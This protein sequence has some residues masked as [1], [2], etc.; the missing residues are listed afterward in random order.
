LKGGELFMAVEGFCVKCK[1][2]REIKD[3]Q[4]VMMK[5]GRP[6]VKGVCPVC[7]TGMFRIKSKAEQGAA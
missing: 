2:K 1:E 7:G 3:A 4:D 5:N 6:A